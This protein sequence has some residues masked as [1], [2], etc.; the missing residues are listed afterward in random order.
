MFGKSFTSSQLK[1]IALV[2]MFFDHIVSAVYVIGSIEYSILHIPGRIVAPIFCFL[3][4][5]S[6]YYTKN[7]K[8][9]L[10]RLFIFALVSH[11]PYILFFGFIFW[12]TTSVMW[13]LTL[14]VLA[15][16][17]YDSNYNKLI[18]ISLILLCCILAYKGDW[19]FVTVLWILTFGIFRKN[20]KKQIISFI[21]IGLVF[22]IVPII[23]SLGWVFG[24]RIGIFLSIPFLLSYS[25]KRGN[26]TKSLQHFFYGFYPAHF[27]IILFVKELVVNY[28]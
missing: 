9:Y 12:S 25:G 3:I 4:A 10:F 24:Y 28:I 1:I 18:K 13:G 7:K 19:S 27:M 20:I 11:I 15:L 6:Y 5:E 17:I 23:F 22:Y 16:I 26:N 8:K 14:G 21:S 2:L